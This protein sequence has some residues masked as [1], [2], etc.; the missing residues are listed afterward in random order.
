VEIT[1]TGNGSRTRRLDRRTPP[2]LA[3]SCYSS[4]AKE[5]DG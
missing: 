3:G 1:S 2:G 5:V 4:V